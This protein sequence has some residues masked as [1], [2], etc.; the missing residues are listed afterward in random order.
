VTLFGTVPLALI[1]VAAFIAV[2]GQR[3]AQCLVEREAF[4]RYRAVLEEA[5]EVEGVRRQ[6][7]QLRLVH[8]RTGAQ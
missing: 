2:C 1:F 8:A 3:I 4:A 7:G 6:A 5:L